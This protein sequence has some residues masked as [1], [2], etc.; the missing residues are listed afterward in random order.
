MTTEQWAHYGRVIAGHTTL[1]QEK[2]TKGQLEHGGNCWEKPGMLAHALDEVADLP[3]YLY[4]VK[5]QLT[6]IVAKLRAGDMTT[7]QA[8]DAIER[9]MTK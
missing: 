9:L 2:Y 3:V 4:T 7:A 6:G 8:A 5:E 1:M